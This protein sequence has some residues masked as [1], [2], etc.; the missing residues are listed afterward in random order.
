MKLYLIRHGESTGNLAGR[1]QGTDDYPL[2]ELGKQQAEYVA[3][4]FSDI[5]LDFIYSSDLTRASDTAKAIA[6]KKNQTVNEWDKVREVHLG[7][8]QGLTRAEITMKFP[9]TVENSI[10]TSGVEGTESVDE[11]T[12]RCQ[13]IVEQLQLAH[14][15]HDVAIISHG[16]FISIFLMYLI[17]GDQW[18]TLHR[19]FQIGNTSV[20]FIEWPKKQDKPLIHF[21]NQVSHLDPIVDKKKN[22]GLL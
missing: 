15:N 21:V 2:S 8:L 7:P 22:H 6:R 9:E 20:S 19:P 14:R 16:G 4:Y 5:H 3:D 17:A 1:I 18:H 10:L 11:L 12:A 13:Y